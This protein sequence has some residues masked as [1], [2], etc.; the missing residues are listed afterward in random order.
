[1]TSGVSLR[2]NVPGEDAEIHELLRLHIG[3]VQRTTEVCLQPADEL[4]E[5][6][7]IDDTARPQIEIVW[8]RLRVE[9]HDG[10]R[11]EQ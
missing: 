2:S 4:D 11:L 5:P 10:E 1:V 9:T 8:H 7:R 6:E 3:Q